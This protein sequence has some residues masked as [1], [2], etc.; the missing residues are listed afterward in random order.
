MGA[1]LKDI[2]KGIVD[3][4]DKTFI[5]SKVEGA[6]LITPKLY[7]CSLKWLKIGD[8]ILDDQDRPAT[9]TQVGSN[10]VV[11]EKDDPFI[12]TSKTFTVQTT[13]YFK[14]GTPLDVNSEWLKQNNN[15]D[16][17]LP[18]FFMPLPTTEQVY[19]NGQ[20]LARLSQV[21]IFAI[22]STELRYSVDEHYS[23]VMYY[24]EAY[25][26]AF[27]DAIKKNR[28]DFDNVDLYDEKEFYRFGSESLEGFEANVLDSNLSAKELRFA[29]PIKSGAKCLC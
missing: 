15:V 17:K 6:E 9:V 4:I 24:I 5:V 3:S 10:F 1:F 29:L 22:Q 21:R 23:N 14:A 7:I 2:V 16:L 20:G 18:M 26:E 12:W 13:F 25:C 28:R 27:K 8:V 11:V 19:A